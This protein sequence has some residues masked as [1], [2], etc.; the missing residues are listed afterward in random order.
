MVTYVPSSVII[1]CILRM[2]YS[3]GTEYFDL[4]EQRPTRRRYEEER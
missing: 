2:V 1:T 4:S 3:F